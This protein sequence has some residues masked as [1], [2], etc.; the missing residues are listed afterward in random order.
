MDDFEGRFFGWRV[1]FGSNKGARERGARRRGVVVAVV[2][3]VV[4]EV[5]EA[6]DDADARLNEKRE[7]KLNLADRPSR[8]FFLGLLPISS[9]LTL[10]STNSSLPILISV[11]AYLEYST[12]SPSLRDLAP[13]FGAAVTTPCID[14]TC[15]AEGS[16]MP[17]AEVASASSTLTKTRSPRGATVLSCRRD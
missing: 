15:A 7:T 14:L 4:V 9:F 3:L 2:V 10:S 12:R 11:P 5:E 1:G 16:R 6:D 8:V 17:P 13:P